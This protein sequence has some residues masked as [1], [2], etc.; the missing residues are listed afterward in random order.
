MK[1]TVQLADPAGN[2]TLLVKTPV[3]REDY[4]ALAHK[5][6]SISELKAQQVGFLVP[7]TGEG[8][9]RLE[10]MGGEF[11]GNALR[12][13]GLA[14]AAQR[15]IRR[16]RKLPVEIS[17]CQEALMV[18]PNP[19]AGQVTAQMPLPLGM[20]PH[21]FLGETETPVVRLPGIVH[22]IVKGTDLPPEDT[23][24]QALQALSQALDAPAA[25][26]MFWDFRAQALVPAVYVR[27]TDSLYFESSCASGSSAVAAWSA[28][29][30]REGRHQLDIRQPGGVISTTAV[31]Q[32][33]RL[34]KLS[35]GGPV[36]LGPDY[37][38]EF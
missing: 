26:A 10:M 7:P 21:P 19:L 12:C 4:P 36:T 30:G 13:A 15:G 8:V 38:I 20:E 28:L 16:E 25:G 9:V 2:I 23:L 37:E 35:I 32:G 33:G 17:G 1:L 5:L 14:F 27:G 3:P 24:R 6:L 22:A 18:H 29:R 11:C 31:T 34:K